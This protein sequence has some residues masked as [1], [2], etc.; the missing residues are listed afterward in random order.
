MSDIERS[1]NTMQASLRNVRGELNGGMNRKEDKIRELK[2]IEKEIETEERKKSE[3][4]DEKAKLEVLL[5][6]TRRIFL[7]LAR[8]VNIIAVER[9]DWLKES[10]EGINAE[11][12]VKR[13]GIEL[14]ERNSDVG[15]PERQ[16]LNRKQKKIFKMSKFPTKANNSHHQFKT[17]NIYF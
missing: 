9:I 11:E 7:N 15:I 5:G 4:E 13:Q 16:I 10:F 3:S 2:G 12:R 1:L 8:K 17:L 14:M 6:T